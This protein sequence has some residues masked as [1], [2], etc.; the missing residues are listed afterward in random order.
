[1]PLRAVQIIGDTLG[2]A[3]GQCHQMPQVGGMGSA[4]VSRDIFL[5]KAIFWENQ[6]VTPHRGRDGG[7][8]Q[9]HQMGEGA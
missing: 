4:K 1:V 7:P 9:C 3:T 8:C 2:G 5:K 6:N